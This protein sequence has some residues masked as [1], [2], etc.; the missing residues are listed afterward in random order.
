[1]LDLQFNEYS[2]FYEAPLHV[3]AMGG[4]FLIDDLGRQLVEPEA[5][6]NRWIP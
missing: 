3:K 2:K 5:L 6:L 1:M 4:T